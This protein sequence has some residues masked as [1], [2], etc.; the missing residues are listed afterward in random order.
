[1][2]ALPFCRARARPIPTSGVIAESVRLSI[3]TAH[4]DDRIRREL[5]EVGAESDDPIGDLGLEVLSERPPEQTI[6]PAEDVV[7][8]E[9]LHDR[10]PPLFQVAAAL[11]FGRLSTRHRVGTDRKISAGSKP[12]ALVDGVRDRRR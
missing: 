7:V 6:Q 8:R 1:M 2:S 11:V 9:N 12:G 4:G 5:L 10:K 3:A